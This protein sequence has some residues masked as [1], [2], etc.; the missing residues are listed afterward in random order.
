M[1]DKQNMAKGNKL[2]KIFRKPNI[3]ESDGELLIG[4][5]KSWTCHKIHHKSWGRGA[6][7][8]TEAPLPYPKKS[9]VKVHFWE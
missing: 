4:A 6:Q 3:W 9:T 8:I 5:K 2:T 1:R 7:T